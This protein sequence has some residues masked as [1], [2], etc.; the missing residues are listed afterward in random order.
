MDSIESINSLRNENI[1]ILLD[2]LKINTIKIFL[3]NNFIDYD[4]KK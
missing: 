3:Q 1:N 2:Q 4:D